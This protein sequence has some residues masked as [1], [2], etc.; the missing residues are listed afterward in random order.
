MGQPKSKMLQKIQTFQRLFEKR[1][2]MSRKNRKQF[3]ELK[4][5]K[6]EI[7]RE[8]AL[9]AGYGNDSFTCLF[10]CETYKFI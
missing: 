10:K 5:A 7:E 3:G 1:F 2:K 8:A 6:V 4:H 9:F